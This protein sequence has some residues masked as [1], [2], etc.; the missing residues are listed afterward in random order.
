MSVQNSERWPTKQ[1]EIYGLENAEGMEDD[2]E[3]R[4]HKNS[5]LRFHENPIH[6]INF[7]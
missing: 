7:N 4:R 6:Y 1:G 3:S 2:T 5:A